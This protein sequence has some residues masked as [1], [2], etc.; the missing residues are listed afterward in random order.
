MGDFLGVRGASPLPSW[1]S[2]S[3]AASKRVID[4]SE[5][6][7]GDQSATVQSATI[8]S[9]VILQETPPLSVK[10]KPLPQDEKQKHMKWRGQ[11]TAYEINPL[12]EVYSTQ[13]LVDF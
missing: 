10:S 8:G 2:G 4:S 1:C 6:V 11:L 13:L 7:S 3:I 5:T 9:S 12:L